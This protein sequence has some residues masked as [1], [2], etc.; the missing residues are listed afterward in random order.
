MNMAMEES[1]R[2]MDRLRIVP[3]VTRNRRHALNRESEG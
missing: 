2:E 3:Y 1:H